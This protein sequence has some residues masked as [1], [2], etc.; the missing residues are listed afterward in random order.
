M[1]ALIATTDDSVNPTAGYAPRPSTPRPST[2]RP[3]TPRNDAAARH[4]ASAP[5]QVIAARADL[6][7]E[8]DEATHAFEVLDGIVCACR[9]LPD[10][11][12]HIIAFYYPGDVLGYCCMDTHPYSAQALTAVRVRRIPLSLLER[13]MQQRPEVAHKFLRLATLELS[14]TRDHLVC[15]AVKSAAAKTASFLLAL[16]RRN[17]SVGQDS[18]QIRLPM[19]RLDIADYLGLTFETVSRMLSKFKRKGLIDLPRATH[20]VIKDVMGLTALVDA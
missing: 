15:L 9:L 7:L 19:T 8:G 18:L 16:S 4:F 12:R 1:L 6:F 3:L 20:V 14:A 17:A 11:A 13:T 2:P 5:V 10:G